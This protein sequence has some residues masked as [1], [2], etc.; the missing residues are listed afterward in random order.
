MYKNKLIIT[1]IQNIALRKKI[2]IIMFFSLFFI[3]IAYLVNLHFL[4]KQYDNDMYETNAQLLNN[5]IS[6]IES[7]MSTITNISNYL[8]ADATIQENLTYLLD[9]NSNIKQAVVKRNAYEALYTYLFSNDYIKSISLVTEDSIITMGDTFYSTKIELSSINQ[10]AEADAGRVSWSSGAQ[11]NYS[12]LCVREIRQLKYLKLRKLAILYIDVDMEQII[13]DA[14]SDAGYSP[15]LVDFIVVQGTEQIYPSETTHDLSLLLEEGTEKSYHIDTIDGQKKFIISGSMRYIDWNYYYFRDYDQIFAHI[16]RAKYYTIFYTFLFSVLALL[17]TNYSLKSIL[18]HLDYLVEKIKQFGEGIIKPQKKKYNYALRK[19]EIGT[20]HRSFDQMTHS[21]KVL[22]DENYDKQILLKDTT[23]KMLEQ[24]INPH[25]L[26]NTLDTINWMAQMYGV[27]DIATMA[28]SLG[29]LFRASISEQRDLILLENEL[30]FLNNYI[31][32]QTIRFK[33]RLQFKILIDETYYKILIPKLSIQPL[34]ENALQHSMECSDEICK[35]ELS[36][37]EDEFKY[38]IKVANTGSYFVDNLLQKLE[39][40]TLK[41]HG[42][43]IGLTN[44]N[45]RM[46]L[47]YGENYGLSFYNEN[48]MAIVVLT[49]PKNYTQNENL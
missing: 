13:T 15:N 12:M 28:L 2:T 42:S 32:I 18:K 39:E 35:I 14:L 44:I 17:L 8:T 19:D 5:V 30:E 25:F 48:Q 38:L 29:N 7:E 20:L 46:K 43:G 23:I 4:T 22:R 49:I 40:H 9:N 26:Y 34:V 41:P 33:E 3:C 36:I 37:E 21:V 16:T 47:I 6:N 24:Q 11:A 45:S 10:R 31:L 1:A 27:D